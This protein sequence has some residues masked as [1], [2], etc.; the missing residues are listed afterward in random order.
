MVRVSLARRLASRPCLAIEHTGDQ[1]VVRC[2]QGDE[3]AAPSLAIEH[4]SDQPW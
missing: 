3:R 1:P 2:V 4:T